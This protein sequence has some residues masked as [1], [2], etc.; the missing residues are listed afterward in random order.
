MLRKK[1][2]YYFCARIKA[3]ELC[4]SVIP[5]VNDIS[6]S[7][8]APRPVTIFPTSAAL[9]PS[10]LRRCWKSVAEREETCCL[11]PAWDAE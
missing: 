5:T 6:K 1:I 9:C 3:C 11:L 4:K 2:L 8:G 10:S 7:R